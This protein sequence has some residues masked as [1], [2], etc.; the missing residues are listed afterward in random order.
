MIT[1]K[2]L[3]L[4]TQAKNSRAK[5]KRLDALGKTNAADLFRSD[6]DKFDAEADALE[7]L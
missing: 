4:R 3:R 1:N 5:A 2:V 7:S 6:A